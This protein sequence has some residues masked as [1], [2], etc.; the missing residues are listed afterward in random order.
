[1]DGDHQ[2]GI[3]QRRAEVPT[4]LLARVRAAAPQAGVNT[5][6]WPALSLLRADHPAANL[7]AVYE[8]SLCVVVQG[9]KRAVLGPDSFQYD[10][11]HFLVVSLTL[12][13]IAHI[14]DASVDRPYLCIRLALDPVAVSELLLHRPSTRAAGAAESRRGLYMAPMST[15][16]A[17][18]LLRLMRALD[19]PADL[20]IL[21]PML[22]REVCYRVLTGPL[23]S[24]LQDLVD[25]G[26]HARR[27]ARAIELIRLQVDQPLRVAHLADALH[28]SESSLHHRFKQLTTLTPVQFQKRLRLHE[29]RRLMQSEGLAAASAGL[30]VGYQ[31]AS[32]FSRDYRRLFGAPPR[33]SLAVG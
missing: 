32:Q 20:P 18:A 23:G 29:A 13:V 22:M 31:S 25:S 7:P 3:G 1:M 21:A 26:G 10:A 9:S 8:P 6:A 11:G 19:V 5:S 15:E 4:E 12:P 17:D 30:R 24:R 2:P 16:L 33:R 27:I 14:L 28:M